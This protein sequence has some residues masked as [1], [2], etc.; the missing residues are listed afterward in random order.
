MIDKD[1]EKLKQ[2]IMLKKKELQELNDVYFVET[3]RSTYNGYVLVT[4]TC[5]EC[6]KELEHVR[7]GKWQCSN[8]EGEKLQPSI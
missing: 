7:P 3:G 6:N 1:F 4:P 8:C 2:E 5:P